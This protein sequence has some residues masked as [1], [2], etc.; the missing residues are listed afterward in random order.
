VP[1][2]FRKIHGRLPSNGAIVV[3]VDVAPEPVNCNVL[4]L[5]A[6][7]DRAAAVSASGCCATISTASV[8]VVQPRRIGPPDM[9]GRAYS[10][11]RPVFW[12][13]SCRLHRRTRPMPHVRKA[14]TA[15]EGFVDRRFS[16]VD[17]SQPSDSGNERNGWSH[18]RILFQDCD[19]RSGLGPPIA[20]EQ[21][22]TNREVPTSL[23]YGKRTVSSRTFATRP[24][25]LTGACLHRR[26]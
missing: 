22:F 16:E 21:P 15:T 19:G 10:E 18:G 24:F 25:V 1:R 12:S 2:D 17:E 7:S 20:R 13:R 4:T 26:G 9:G 5:L 23:L 6:P 14:T 3:T 11:R 8:S